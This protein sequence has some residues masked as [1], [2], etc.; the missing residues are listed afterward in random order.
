[1][2]EL[3]VTQ[4]LVNIAVSE[5]E[6]AGAKKVTDLNLVMGKCT[7]LV[8][9]I[10]QDYFAL[11]SEGTIAEAANI[12]IERIP[13]KIHCNICNADFV[14][15]DFRVVCPKCKGRDTELIEGKEFYVDFIE[16]EE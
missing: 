5:G 6:K 15:P 10:V 13:G 16:I 11:M 7:C 8:P 14:I 9:E 4:S 1:M 2:H 3:S 12:H